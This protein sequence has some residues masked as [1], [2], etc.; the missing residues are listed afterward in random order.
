VVSPLRICYLAN[1][2][3]IHTVR[4]ARHFAGAGH[5]ITV[6]SYEP[7]QIDGVTVISLPKVV[8]SRHLNIVAGALLA[9]KVVKEC[10]PDIVHAHYVTSYGL[11]GALLKRDRPFIV[12]AWGSDVLTLP[13]ESQ[14]YR[15]LVRFVLRRAD[16]VTSVAPHMTE[17]L[18]QSGLANR[19]KVVTIPFGTDTTIFNGNDR[20]AGVA[21]GPVILSTRRLD[22][23]LDVDVLV[24]A[25]HDVIKLH[26]A[27]R[28]EVV[29]DGT[30]R[31][32]IEQMTADL[33]LSNN[34]SFLGSLA[35][36][37]VAHRLQ[38]A[39]IFVSTPPSDGNNVSLN[40]AMACGTFPVVSDIDANRAWIH[41]GVNGLM[42]RTGDASSLASVVRRAVESPDLRARAQPL[43]WQIVQTRASWQNSTRAMQRLYDDV[44]AKRGPA[45]SSWAVTTA[46][47]PTNLH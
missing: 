4:W 18:G 28:F 15:R 37:A 22:R 24:R 6:V 1:A 39:D 34:V 32:D 45:G 47:A 20:V 19:Q 16:I 5:D 8:P 30:E 36:H 17:Y 33:G 46:D 40:E 38:R 3:S 14:M 31:R 9:Q 35:P 42:F 7:A 25:A 26:P 13:R 29:G 41:D 2:Q 11:A 12:S 23:G 10:A 43:N 27:A 44:L 21:T